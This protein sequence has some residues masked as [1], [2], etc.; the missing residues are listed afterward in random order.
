QRRGG[1]VPTGIPRSHGRGDRSYGRPGR[2]VRAARSPRNREGPPRSGKPELQ[3]GEGRVVARLRPPLPLRGAGRG[4]A[5]SGAAVD[6]GGG[7]ASLSLERRQ[8]ILHARSVRT[9]R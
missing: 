5:E 1:S 7:G 6:G 8:R 4:G 9:D 2:Q 3:G